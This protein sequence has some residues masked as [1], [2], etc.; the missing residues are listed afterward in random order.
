LPS[1]AAD[2]A[3]RIS[4]RYIDCAKQIRA[5][6]KFRAA[7]RDRHK[8]RR[9]R[10]QTPALPFNPFSLLE[11]QTATLRLLGRGPKKFLLEQKRISTRRVFGEQS[12]PRKKA[13]MLT[14][15]SPTSRCDCARLPK[16]FKKFKSAHR[17][18]RGRASEARE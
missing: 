2:R 7:Y 8:R 15:S 4:P 9:P 16:G 5:A 12:S 18:E 1:R 3:H 17:R 14:R 6:R 13:I 10:S 11:I